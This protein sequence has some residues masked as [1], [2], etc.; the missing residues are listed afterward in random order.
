MSLYDAIEEVEKELGVEKPEAVV[1]EPVKEAAAAEPEKKEEAPPAEDA[2]PAAEAEKAP[3]AA[4]FARL[5]RDEAAARRRAEAAEAALKA[6]VAAPVVKKEEPSVEPDPNTDPEGHLRWELAQTKAQLK[7]VADYTASIRKEKEQT[8]LKDNAVKAFTSYE[9]AFKV[10][11]P[12]YE[13][14]TKF[15]VQQLAASISRLNPSLR[16]A[17]LSDA[18]QRQVL[19]LAGQ[20]E[21]QGHDPA[22]Y[23]YHMSKSWGYQPPAPAAAKTEAEVV[24]PK[25]KDIVE[26]K[27]KSAS[28]L[29]AGGKSGRTAMSKE[30]L[31]AMPFHEVASLSPA[32]L[33]EWEAL[34][35]AG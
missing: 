10:S 6:P 4:A 30:A 32:D 27:K 14:V 28:S 23:F 9:D 24:K 25:L 26:H 21:Q 35:A 22:E 15:G 12:D 1:E 2:K 13:E 20:A 7:E 17:E 5:R 33:R 18:I 11:A 3:D 34:E 29:A 19:R 8:A 31:A 16:G